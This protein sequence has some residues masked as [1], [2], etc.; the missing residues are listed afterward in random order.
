MGVP[1]FDNHYYAELA[2]HVSQPPSAITSPCSSTARSARLSERGTSWTGFRIHMVDG[3]IL[4]PRALDTEDL[5]DRRDPDTA[6]AD[7]VMAVR[8]L[9]GCRTG[10]AE[11]CHSGT[12]SEWSSCRVHTG[13]MMPGQLRARLLGEHPEIGGLFCFNDEF[14]VRVVRDLLETCTRVPDDVAVIGIDGLDLCEVTRPRISTFA[15][16]KAAIA[17]SALTML[18]DRID[19]IDGNEEPPRHVR[20]DFSFVVRESTRL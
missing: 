6:A 12:T 4:C 7:D 8:R 13:P 14:A 11:A 17:E 2:R 16:D 1:S 18:I 15:P 9:E 10:L 5:R 3:L 20:A 19:R